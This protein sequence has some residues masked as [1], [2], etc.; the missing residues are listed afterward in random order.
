MTSRLPLLTEVSP[1]DDSRLATNPAGLTTYLAPSNGLRLHACVEGEGELV[2]LVHGW[3]QCWYVWR[4]QIPYLASAG[5]R[6]CAFDQR[7]YGNSDRPSRVEDY[8]IGAVTANVVG[9]ADALGA[10]TFTVVGQDWGCITAWH[11]ALL[12]PH[13]VRGVF[14]F[15]APYVP[16]MLRNWIDPPQYRDSFWYARY[17]LQPGV[18]EAELERDLP[19]FLMWMWHAASGGTPTNVLDITCG[20]PRER[21]LLAGLGATPTDVPGHT[22]EDL[23]YLIGLYRKSG[24][25]GSLNYYRNMARL[26]ELTPWLDEARILPPA[27]FAYGDDEPVARRAQEADRSRSRSALDEQDD[28]FVDLLGKVCIADAGHWPMVEQ[29]DAVNR[30]IAG[31]LATIGARSTQ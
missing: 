15:S 22:Q 11:V 4:H 18:A 3:P 26:A 23:D 12:Y 20:G 28:Y 14:G 24:I 10:D 21:E 16:R 1:D 13:R 2:I 17:F 25:R 9:L 6:V 30:L 8:D 31:F 7:G 27:M 5:Y 19:R 29:P